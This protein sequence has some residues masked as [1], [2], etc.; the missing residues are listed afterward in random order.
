MTPGGEPRLLKEAHDVV[1]GNHAVDAGFQMTV[2]PM[3]A[4]LGRL[5]AIMKLNGVTSEDEA[6]SSRYSIQFQTPG[7]EIGWS[8]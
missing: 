3:S 2:L 7:E 1:G 4:E 8:S 5:P 6:S